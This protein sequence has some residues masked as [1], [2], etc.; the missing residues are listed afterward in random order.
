MSMGILLLL[1]CLL[2]IASSGMNRMQHKRSNTSM[3]KVVFVHIPQASKG[4]GMLKRE[5]FSSTSRSS[6]Q[7]L[8][9]FWCELVQC[10]LIIVDSAVDHVGFFLLQQNHSRL[11]GILNTKT[12]DNTRT[13]LT[14]TMASI[15]TLP[16]SSR[17][18]PATKVS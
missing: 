11:Y 9:V 17:V 15:S 8:H 2:T 12:S 3:L 7:E 14:N 16:F 10:N 4:V 13:S 1:I 6:E 5:R 18:P